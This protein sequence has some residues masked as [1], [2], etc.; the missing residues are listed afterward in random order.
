MQI[1]K[2]KSQPS[3]LTGYQNN[4]VKTD[5]KDRERLFKKSFYFDNLLILKEITYQS[6]NSLIYIRLT[7]NLTVRLLR[8]FLNF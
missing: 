8:I 3:P 1:V 7:S 5:L 6:K 2:V 4:S